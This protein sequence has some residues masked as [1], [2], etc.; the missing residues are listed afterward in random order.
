MIL[1]TGGAGYIGSHCV[2]DL[3]KNGMDVVVFDNL[4]T[5]HIETVEKLKQFGN[6]EFV[7]G[8]L[9]NFDDISGVFNKYKNINAVNQNI[10]LLMNHIRKY[11]S[12]RMGKQN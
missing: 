5:G 6:V 4:S 12:I 9:L 7:H 11:L 2:M 1:V 10:S 3:C 8:D